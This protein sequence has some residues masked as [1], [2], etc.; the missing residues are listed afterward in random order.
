MKFILALTTLL[1]LTN[2][3]IAQPVS[4]QKP[5]SC[6]ERAEAE[7]QLSALKPLGKG[8]SPNG[9][10]FLITEIFTF[11]DNTPIIVEQF[12]GKN[13]EKSSHICVVARSKIFKW[14]NSTLDKLMGPKA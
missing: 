13:G 6:W 14:N 1:V 9:E 4:A 10:G 5:I 3:S 11:P 2:T 12:M 8:I 7:K